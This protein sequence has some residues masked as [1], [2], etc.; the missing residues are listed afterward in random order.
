M[1]PVKTKFKREALMNLL[2]SFITN[3]TDVI[4]FFTYVD[5]ERIFKDKDLVFCIL[6]LFSTSTLQF[7]FT[8]SARLERE[9]NFKK[10]F[11][12][13]IREAVFCTE[14]WSYIFIFCTQDF[15]F[16]ITRTYVIVYYGTE[17]NYLLFFFVIKNY[18]LC[19]FEIYAS[20]NIILDE[21]HRRKLHQEEIDLN[22]TDQ[23]F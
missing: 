14:L 11:W 18:V 3:G 21:K 2:I 4:E 7:S 19:I 1:L 20:V 17:R 15:P 8:L 6:I 9:A 16:M 13:V 22:L 12:E 23:D 10:G 5:E